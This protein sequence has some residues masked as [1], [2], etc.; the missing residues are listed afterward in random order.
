MLDDVRFTMAAVAKRDYVPGLTHFKIAEGRITG[1]NGQMA[2]SSP[3]AVELSARPNAAKF[4]AAVRTCEEGETIALGLTGT[5]RLSVKCGKFKAF[6]E[7]IEDDGAVASEPE[8]E[9]VEL[10]PSFLDGLRLLSPVMGIDASRPWAMGIKASGASL[11]ATNNVVAAQYWHGRTFPHDVVIPSTAVDELLRIGDPPSRVQVTPHSITFHFA[12]ERWLKTSLLDGSAWPLEK[13]E[14]LLDRSFGDAAGL[15][16]IGEPF[17]E[18][19]KKLK[20]F[21]HEDNAVFLLPNSVGTTREE[22][23]GAS[24]ELDLP[25]SGV[26]AYTHQQLLILSEVATAVHFDAYPAPSRFIHAAKP[27][28]GV[29]VGRKLP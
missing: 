9:D 16:E 3:I 29:V 25:V 1:F 8:G 15:V 28:R 20:P 22:G 10:E 19:L 11:Y 13:I 18:A 7:C 17:A 6:V 2:L 12:G 4:L 5:G 23:T 14:H 27:L 24:V 26:Q 21:L